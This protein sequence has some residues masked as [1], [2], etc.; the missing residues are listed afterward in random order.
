MLSLTRI[1]AAARRRAW[2]A[3]LRR[4]KNVRRC[5]VF[6]PTPGSFEN[7]SMRAATGGARS[8][9]GLE[10]PWNLQTTGHIGRQ[11][12]VGLAHLALRIFCCGPPHDFLFCDV[13]RIKGLKVDFFAL[14]ITFA[15]HV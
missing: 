15:F 13:F 7:S 2:S 4:M 11:A 10:Q 1:I 14:N 9:I 8:L 12:L 6:T 3:G 5:A